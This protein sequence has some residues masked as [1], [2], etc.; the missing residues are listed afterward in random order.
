MS[1]A[2]VGVAV[3]DDRVQAA[4]VVTVGAGHLRHVQGIENG[5]VVLVD[6]HGDALSGALV[7]RFQKMAEPFRAGR[8]GR[9]HAGVVFDAV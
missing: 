1:E 7:Q 5:L 8:V 3:L 6:E 4:Q 2:D 9:R